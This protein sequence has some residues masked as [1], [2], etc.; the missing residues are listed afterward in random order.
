MMKDSC[1]LPVVFLCVQYYVGSFYRDYRHGDGVYSWP[2]GH[3]FN[4]KFYLNKKE[5]YGTMQF[6][7]GSTFMVEQS[8]PE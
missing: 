8:F 7:D 4:G 6:S 3:T 2:S 5:G 1:S